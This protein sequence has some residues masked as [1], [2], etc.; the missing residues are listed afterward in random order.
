M[1]VLVTGKSVPRINLCLFPLLLWFLSYQRLLLRRL[2][3]FSLV[4][5]LSE[6][7]TALGSVNRPRV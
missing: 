7:E 1:G 4:K 2:Q 3:F 5:H 6:D